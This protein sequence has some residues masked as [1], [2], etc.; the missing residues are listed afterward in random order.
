MVKSNL[1]VFANFFIDTEERF[2]RM[3]DSYE[4]FEEAQIDSYVINVRGK[5]SH[6]VQKYIKNKNAEA[7][8]ESFETGNGWLYDSS[9]LT[10]YSQSEYILIW[11]E[12]HICLNPTKIDSIINDMISSNSD[13]L[14]Y[15]YW[16]DGDM[17]ERYKHIEKKEMNE[18]FYFDHTMNNHHLVMKDRKSYII[19]MVSIIKRDLFLKILNTSR[20]KRWDKNLPFDFEKAPNDVHWLPIRRAITKYE[21]FASID[22]DLGYK[23]GSLQSRGLYPIREERMSYASEKPSLLKRIKNKIRKYI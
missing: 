12:D 11:L 19:S 4:S 1:S 10:K 9:K 3:I 8:C 18:I 14:T 22:D 15:S 20:E 16:N 23:N 17:I 6:K 7:I 5:Y 21:L 2:L 13:I